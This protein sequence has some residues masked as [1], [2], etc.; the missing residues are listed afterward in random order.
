M[1][2][3]TYGHQ[4]DRELSTTEIAKRI[5]ADIKTAI[6]EGL[7]P[8]APV[9]YSVQSRYFSGGSSIDVTVKGWADA[10]TDGTRNGFDAQVLVPDAEAAKMTLDRIT[11]AYNH[12][13]SD[14]MTDYYDVNFYGHVAFESASS[15]EFRASEKAR[16]AQRKA[17]RTAA[18]ADPEKVQ[19][20]L[21][22][23]RAGSTTHLAVEVDGKVRL[24]CGA[25][26]WRSSL[27]SKTEREPTCSR[28][29][30]KV[31]A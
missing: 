30:K 19:R 18:L 21:V 12:D 15:A 8:G 20:V 9:R 29:S 7:L 17:D 16:L 14:A 2:E 28:C 6:A 31:T 10:W 27:V 1:Y 5:R 24:A 11:G 23:G 26:L 22:F 25:T 4:Y 13:G 3:R